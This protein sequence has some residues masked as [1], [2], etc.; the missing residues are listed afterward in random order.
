[1]SDKI[2]VGPHGVPDPLIHLSPQEQSG[3]VSGLDQ[4]CED[5]VVEVQLD[6]LI[7]YLF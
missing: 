4:D 7:K 2:I 3:D 5:E 6:K 1:M